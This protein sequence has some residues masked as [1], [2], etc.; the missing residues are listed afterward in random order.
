MEDTASGLPVR[1]LLKM[2]AN[3]DIDLATFKQLTKQVVGCDEEVPID[4]TEDDTDTP[5][6]ET[7]APAPATNAAATAPA[8][9]A[10]IPTAVEANSDSEDEDDD[11][12]DDDEDDDDDA[13]EVAATRG[14]LPREEAEA[15]AEA[16]EVEEQPPAKKQKTL[17]DGNLMAFVTKNAPPA[18]KIAASRKTGAF[19]PKKTIAKQ[20]PPSMGRGASTHKNGAR[21]NDV[22]PR[23]MNKR[24]K[25]HPGQSLKLR[26][27]QI[28]CAACNCNVGS[29]KQDCNKHVNKTQKHKDAVAALSTANENTGAIQI[30]IHDYAEAQGE[31]VE[32][33]GLS[34]VPE[35]TQLARAEA[36]E[37]V[38]KAGIPAAKLDKLRPYLERRM[39]ISLTQ[40]NHLCKTFVPALK[41]KE[42]KILRNEFKGEFIGVYHDGTTHHGESF[43]IVF[44]ACLP[45]FVF[46]ICCV[47]LR[48]LRGSMTADQISSELIECIASHMQAAS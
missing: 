47:R 40:A 1:Q 41:M 30:A 28:F 18:A 46:R 3:G 11:D 20:P 34:R 19:T 36:L 24:I 16:E 21:K 48:F 29:S 38:L 17:A 7:E 25:E 6:T 8:A 22:T 12:D 35:E 5:A 15:E 44:R 42:E 39:G 26:G 14:P 4:F 23:T 33:K 45:G 10:H 43:A 32:I 37:E 9:A 2:F 31:G 27:G 13:E